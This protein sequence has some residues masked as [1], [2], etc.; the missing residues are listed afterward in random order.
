MQSNSTFHKKWSESQ[1][2]FHIWEET[3]GEGGKRASQTALSEIQSK[4]NLD[5]LADMIL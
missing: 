2:T 5:F 3:D 4:Y 1:V